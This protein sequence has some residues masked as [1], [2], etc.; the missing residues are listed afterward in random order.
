MRT[1]QFFIDKLDK[2]YDL[3]YVDYNDSLDEH[4]DLVQEA[5][6]DGNMD[7]IYD[8][9]FPWYD[10]QEWETAN[11]CANQCLSQND[12]TDEEID[13]HTD[14]L[15]DEIFNRNEGNP[16]KDLLKHT[17]DK[18]MYYECG[19][20][21]E[22]ES[23]S[24]NEKTLKSYCKKIAKYAKID[25]KENEKK[26]REL[27]LNAS[28]GG[29]LVYLW[30]DRLEHYINDKIKYIEF[31][32]G[33][34]AI[35]DRGNGSG[36][37]IQIKG[38]AK[39]KFDSKILYLDDVAEGYSYSHD[40]CGLVKSCYTK[41]DP[42]LIIG[43]KSR[44]KPESR[45]RENSEYITCGNVITDTQYGSYIRPYNEVG[46]WVGA[47]KEK[48][49]LKEW[50]IEHFPCRIP[51]KV[52]EAIKAHPE[53]LILTNFHINIGRKEKKHIGWILMNNKHKIIYEKA[54]DYNDFGWAK[55]KLLAS[56]AK[57]K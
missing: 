3:S 49:H 14:N 8:E 42:K 51:A 1:L 34:L 21:I 53:Q 36:Y 7:K 35:I 16:V 22:E 19:L 55:E 31:K 20:E 4:L 27:L 41:Y 26:I 38:T 54:E 10:N 52:L 32:D 39:Y 48:G 11:E 47:T 37:D 6:R 43:K 9:V 30:V 25:Y 28:C 5:I 50:D 33:C 23:W 12:A 2:T 24:M 45:F 40:V 15:R 46:T 18:F 17:S 56:I 13:E 29:T 44:P 57:Y